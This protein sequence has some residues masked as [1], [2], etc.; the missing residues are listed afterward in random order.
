[1][2]E[3]L[4]KYRK[5]RRQKSKNGTKLIPSPQFECTFIMEP[6]LNEEMLTSV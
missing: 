5:K 4:D 6:L 2:N 1:M 3:L